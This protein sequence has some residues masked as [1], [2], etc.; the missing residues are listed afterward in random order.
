MVSFLL[1]SIL[2]IINSLSFSIFIL[3]LHSVI[4]KSDIKSFLFISLFIFCV[5]VISIV[6][7]FPY[8]TI[9]L[10]T[11]LSSFFSKISSPDSNSSILFLIIVNDSGP[12]PKIF[13]I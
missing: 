1:K 10:L 4:F 11:L 9:D 7:L 12:P 3:F 2:T 6:I 13:D 5:S 8:I